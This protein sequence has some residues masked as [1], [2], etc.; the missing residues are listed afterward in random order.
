MKLIDSPRVIES[1]H[2]ITITCVHLADTLTVIPHWPPQLLISQRFA[3]TTIT[4]YATEEIEMVNSHFVVCRHNSVA[5][6]R[7]CSFIGNDVLSSNFCLCARENL[8]LGCNGII[9][10]KDVVVP[11]VHIFPRETI[12]NLTRL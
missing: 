2:F 10:D 1:L 8:H 5:V 11:D 7:K 12:A 3:A 9:A 4:G 6:C